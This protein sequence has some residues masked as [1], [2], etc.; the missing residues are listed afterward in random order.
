MALPHQLGGS[1]TIMLEGRNQGAVMVA[2]LLTRGAAFAATAMTVLATA[3]VA[4]AD[5][6]YDQY[7]MNGT[8]SVVSNGEWARMNDR[9]QD[10]PSVRSTWTVTSTCSTAITCAGKVTSTLGWTEDIYTT[11]GS[12]WYVKHYVPDWIPCPDGSTA[13]G[14]QVYKI[15]RATDDGMADVKSPNWLG[16]D[17]TTGVSGNCGRNRSLVLNLPVKIT[18]IS[19]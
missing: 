1:A 5:A 3:P 17:E 7:A 13:P 16:E 12:Q 14:L 8:F 4:A 15:Y 2:T 10:E 9:Y 18:K 11:M 19:D 6:E